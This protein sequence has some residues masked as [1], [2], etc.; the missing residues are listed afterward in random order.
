MEIRK[1]L[2]SLSLIVMTVT[3][4]QSQNGFVSVGTNHNG[5]GGAL[6]QSVG[7]LVYTS[8]NSLN[9]SLLKGVQQPYEVF[10]SIL[11]VNKY[12]E[13]RLD[14]KVY[15]NPTISNVVLSIGKM[16]SEYLAYQLYDLNGRL[17]LSEKIQTQKSTISLE[18][19]PMATYFL[20]I[21]DKALTIKSFKIIKNN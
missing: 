19:L 14:L 4:A 20:I 7:Q 5:V 2:F 3:F 18:K 15:P 6:S 12:P 8:N 16:S 11:S 1:T 17:L 13:I 9:G 21:T 10:E